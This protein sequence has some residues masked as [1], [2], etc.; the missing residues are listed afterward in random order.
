MCFA[1]AFADCDGVSVNLFMTEQ[2]RDQAVYDFLAR[3]FAY[4]T[5][6]IPFGKPGQDSAEDMWVKFVAWKQSGLHGITPDYYLAFASIV[7]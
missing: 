7:T 4:S 2:E 3:D 6:P 5:T 1:Y